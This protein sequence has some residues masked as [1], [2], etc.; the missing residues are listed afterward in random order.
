MNMMSEPLDERVA[1]EFSL[2]GVGKLS[3]KT[4]GCPG[5]PSFSHG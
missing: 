1:I 4:T 3:M 5:S 2:V